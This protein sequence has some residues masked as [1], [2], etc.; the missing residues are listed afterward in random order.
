MEEKER[1]LQLEEERRNEERRVDTLKIVEDV[2]RRE[3][4]SFS[5][6]EEDVPSHMPKITDVDTDDDDVETEYEVWKLRELKRVKRDRD[7]REA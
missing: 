6:A 5:K 2:I 1:Q 3:K 4:G 7:E